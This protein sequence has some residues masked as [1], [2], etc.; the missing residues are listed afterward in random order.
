MH[1]AV[2]LGFYVELHFVGLDQVETAILRVRDRVSKGGHDIPLVDQRRRFPRSFNNLR[3]AMAIADR[4]WLY[5]NSTRKSHILL[6][7]FVKGTH[8]VVQ[9]SWPEWA[10]AAVSGSIA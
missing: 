2:K 4:T 5:D 10:K 3:T 9:K 1:R 7:S 8:P 6:T